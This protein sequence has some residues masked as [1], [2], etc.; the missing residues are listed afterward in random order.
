MKIA[1]FVKSPLTEVVCGV[2]FSAQEFSS[3]HFGLY[4]Q[5]IRDRFPNP[6][7][8]RPPIGDIEIL[9]ILPRLRRVWF[10]SSDQKQ[11]IQLQ[12][13]RFHYNWRQ[14]GEGNHYP[15]FHEIY[16]K[17]AEEWER[18]QSWWND[19]EAIPLQPIRYELTYINQI[20]KNFGWTDASDYP[21]IFGFLNQAQESFP[22]VDLVGL[23]INLSISLPDDNGL[24]SISID[25]GTRPQDGTTLA[26][27]NLTAATTDMNIGLDDWFD[28]AHQ[29][30]VN[31]FLSLISQEIKQDWGFQWLS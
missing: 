18:L 6:P 19:N 30:T 10:E 12:A 8:D 5:T 16:P 28:F 2:E 14:Q 22:S 25:Q 13:N 20:D 21:K 24:L 3:V 11:L 4:W 31:K 26:L 27:L 7:L 9:S 15:H 23:N 29:F 17:F 1:K